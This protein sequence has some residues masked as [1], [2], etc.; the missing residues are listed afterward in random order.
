VIVP[1]AAPL[2]DT[3]VA[4]ADSY[5]DWLSIVTVVVV[6]SIS[7]SVLLL[8]LCMFQVRGGWLVLSVVKVTS[9]D[10]S[11]TLVFRLLLHVCALADYSY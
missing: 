11:K 7:I 2:Q 10:L 8:L 1:S 9:P 4:L 3:F 6:Q 5:F